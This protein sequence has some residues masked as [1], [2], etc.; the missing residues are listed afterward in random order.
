MT[1]TTLKVARFLLGF[2]TPTSTSCRWRRPGILTQILANPLRLKFHCNDNP[3]STVDFAPATDT[4]GELLEDPN[5]HQPMN[6]T[7]TLYEVAPGKVCYRTSKTA[8]PGTCSPDITL[9]PC[10]IYTQ[11]IQPSDHGP[12]FYVCPGYHIKGRFNACGGAMNTIF[13]LRAVAPRGS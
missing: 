13:G 2:T 4:G 5:P 8:P 12:L 6:L 10:S 11:H 7:W 1:P 9:D 3:T